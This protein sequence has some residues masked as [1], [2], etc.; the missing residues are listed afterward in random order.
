M[1]C[2]LIFAGNSWGECEDGTSG[3]GCGPQE[4]FRNCA[5]VQITTNTVGFPPLPVQRGSTALSSEE[6]YEEGKGEERSRLRG[7]AEELLSQNLRDFYQPQFADETEAQIGDG[8]ITPY[9]SSFV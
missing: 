3:M 7:N 1:K 9:E 2:P 8:I 6:Q 4:I 5:D